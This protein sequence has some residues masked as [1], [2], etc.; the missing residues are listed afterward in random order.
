MVP[1]TL[2]MNNLDIANNLFLER[3]FSQAIEE[4]T[5]ILKNDSQNLT[6]LNNMGYA[7]TKLKKFDLALECY[8]KSLEIKGDDHIVLVNKISLFRKIGKVDLSLI[9]I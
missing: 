9:H 3:K 6:A 2:I 8:E 5:K 7:L 1:T 4:Y